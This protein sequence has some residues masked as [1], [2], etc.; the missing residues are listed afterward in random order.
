ML[1]P[2]WKCRVFSSFN[3]NVGGGS[4]QRELLYTMTLAAVKMR[5]MYSDLCKLAGF[6]NCL[7]YVSP[8]QS[9]VS[10]IKS[11][12][13]HLGTSELVHEVKMHLLG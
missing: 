12:T 2:E 10:C 5:K 8:L 6:D 13:L 11:F 4:R 9:L 7:V 1:R 3:G